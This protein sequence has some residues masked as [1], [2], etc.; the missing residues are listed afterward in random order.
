M[1]QVMIDTLTDSNRETLDTWVLRSDGSKTL[2]DDFS[3]GEK[4]WILKALR[5]ARTIIGKERS[6][7]DIR[8]AFSDE[9]DGAL[10]HGETSENFIRMFRAFIDQADIDTCFYISHK[11]ECISMADH[12]I[13]FADGGVTAN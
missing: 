6:G 12:V 4:V 10:R 7:A 11:P 2:L 9:E 8:T 13:N 5:L 1:F 3:G